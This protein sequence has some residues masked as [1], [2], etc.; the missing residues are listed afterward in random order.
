MNANTPKSTGNGPETALFVCF[1]GMSNTG[2]LTGLA[3]IEVM[4]RV[5]RDK[6]CIFCLGGLPT[7]APTVL[8]ATDNARRIITVDGCTV[9]CARKIVEAA[10]YT[11]DRSITL[12][13]D[14]QITKKSSFDFTEDDLQ[15]VVQAILEALA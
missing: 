7:Q 11:P 4:K 12:V 1:G 2:M 13:T 15:T 8:K 5:G 9:N 14:C 3:G 6:A 10:G